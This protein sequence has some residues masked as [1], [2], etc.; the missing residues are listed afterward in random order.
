M[1]RPLIC[2]LISLIAGIM[3]G[4]YFTFSPNTLLIS[5]ALILV[6]IFTSIR[7]K[8]LTA[9]LL[10]VICFIFL[11]G[12]FNIQKQFYFPK[13]NLNILSYINQGKISVE[14][15]VIESPVT[16]QDKDV[17]IVRCVRIIKDKS[18]IQTAGII[19][20]AIPPELNFRYGDFVRFQSNLKKIQ[21]FNNPGRFN[22]ERYMNLQGIYVSGFVNDS[23]EIILIRKNTAGSIRLKLESFRNYLK[24]II[25]KNSISPEKEII[26][27]MTL[28]NQN[29]IPADI[30]ENF[31]K[32][33]TSHILSISG[34]HIGMVAGTFFLIIFLLL[35]SSEYLMLR[36]N[37]I[38][39]AAATAFLMVLTYALIAGMGVTVMRSALMAF[40][41][42][43][44]LL[45][46][47]QKDFYNTLAIA[48][49]VI[50]AISPEALFDISF[51]LSFMSVWAI[52]YIVPRFSIISSEI[53]SAFPALIQSII[54]Y[55]YLS[56]VV[57]I[58][59]TIGTLPLIIYYFDRVSLVTIIANMIAVPLLGTLT[60]AV[61]MFFILFSFYPSISGYFVQLASFLTQISISFINRLAA[62]SWSSIS[63]TKPNIIEIVFFYFLIFFI[64]Q[65]IDERKK[66]STNNKYSP[67]RFAALKYLSVIIVLF[68][69]TDITYLTFRDK[70]SSDLKVTIIDVGQGYSTLLQFPGGEN[71][72][73]DGGGFAKGSF[74]V[75][76]GVITP[77]LY[78]E[79]IGQIDTAVLSHPHPDHLL[80]LI[81]ILNNFA[82]RQ[83][84]K[85]NLDV[86]SITYPEWEKAIKLNKINVWMLSSKS[87]ENISNGVAVKI[88]WP[89]D[90]SRKDR[91]SFSYDEVNDS[92]LVLKITF[93]KISFLFP[94]DISTEIEKQLIK[95]G[96]DLK[97]DV[98]IVPHHGSN[99]SSSAE[100]IKAVS[101]RYAIVSAGKSNVFKHPH[102]SVLQRFKEAGAEIFRT[103]QDGAINFTTNGDNLHINTFLKNK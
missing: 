31:S 55:V 6:L 19:R 54:R 10:L 67:L 39:I 90:Y 80:G 1:R 43:I 42:L 25:N 13:D 50:L 23:S 75:G 28:G 76:K 47:K 88:L 64:I 2:L 93:G 63:V 36:F 44:A 4:S 81:Y 87:P 45:S 18:Y 72:L 5:A 66:K 7:E 58:A 27:A 86:D 85:S 103:D 8:W 16:Y 35:K 79:R 38:K 89:P 9:G 99:H 48:G 17:L 62:L 101:C 102:P 11:L 52:I 73:I 60:L 69:A 20:L 3:A 51:Q 78:H 70:F 59:A 61:S 94:G 46:G 95:S 65:F 68:F 82:V 26:E 24:Q 71:M 91:N 14:G 32:T 34:L 53:F 29:E 37:I 33:G 77:F 97:S 84:W 98:L 92:S 41:F 22:Y 56:A 83:I 74:N 30:M 100:F 12:F 15:M 21:N 57:C 49:L 96:A 40:I